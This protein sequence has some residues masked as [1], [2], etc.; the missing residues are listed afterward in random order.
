MSEPQLQYFTSLNK[1]F[2]IKT[3]GLLN[4]QTITR[5]A[6]RGMIKPFEKQQIRKVDDLRMISYGL[7]GYGYDVR[8]SRKEFKIFQHLPGKIVDPKNFYE[9]FLVDAELHSDATGE[10]F[11]LPGNTYGLGVLVE[12]LEIPDD[13]LALFIG[14][15]TYARCGA[16]VNLTPGENGWRGY[17][18]VELSN[19]AHSDLKV[20]ANEGIAQALFFRGAPTSICYAGRKYQDQGHGVVV[21]KV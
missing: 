10:Y 16:I 4:A 17:L 7:G 21:A 3:T 20:Y 14:K 6:L 19:S 18:T 2:N 13:V 1:K 11:I 15:S 5:L 8:L 9:G 12:Y